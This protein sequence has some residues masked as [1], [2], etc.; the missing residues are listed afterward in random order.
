[1]RGSDGMQEALFTVARLED[2][3]PK[4]GSSDDANGSGP[5]GR[6][7]QAFKTPSEAFDRS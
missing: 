1:M 7:A 6:N 4:D 2:F 3:L 5:G